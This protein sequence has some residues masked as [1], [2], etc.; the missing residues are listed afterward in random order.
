MFEH[1]AVA[2][3]AV[4]GVPNDEFGEEVKAVVELRPEA[5]AASDELAEE[6]L[7]FC[8]SKLAHYKCPRSIDFVDEL[9]RTPTGKVRKRDLRQALLGRGPAPADRLRFF[10][11]RPG[12]RP[13]RGARRR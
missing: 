9:P 12:R 11:W 10:R 3:V 5:G 13:A 7:A 2:D 8:R 6:L 1:P 4:I